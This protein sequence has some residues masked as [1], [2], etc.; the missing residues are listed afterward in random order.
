MVI[1]VFRGN[2][3]ENLEVFLR[4]YKIACIGTKLKTIIEWFNLFP[5]F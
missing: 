5:K 1:P 2:K 4:E 3:G